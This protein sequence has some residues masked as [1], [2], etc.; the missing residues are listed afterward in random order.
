MENVENAGA[1]EGQEPDGRTLHYGEFYNRRELAHEADSS[2]GIAVVMGNCQAESLRIMLDG[3]GLHTVRV[4]PVHELVGTDIPFLQRL[5]ERTT[6]LVSQPVRDDYHGLPVGLRQLSSRLAGAARAIAFPV[7]RFAG[8]YPVHAIIRPPSD[9]S[10]TPPVVAYHDLRTLAEASGAGAIA[11]SITP[12]MVRAIAADSIGELVRREQ[13]FDA[14]RASDLFTRPDFAQMRTLN[15]PGNAVFAAV[16][17]RVRGRAGLAEHTVDPGR[18]LLDGVH[19]PRLAAVID[20]YELDE[21]PGSDWI[22]GGSTVPDALVRDAH[23]EW[24]AEHPDAVEAGLARH[25][26]ALE[27]LAGA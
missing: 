5:L 21:E 18:R 10:L 23:L 26:R 19:A 1:E 2:A 22:V 11:A 27:I 14:V 7:I 24:Y 9:L 25:G 12:D 20:A 4:P 16:A 13:A 17:E 6:L 3:A 8:L 15:H